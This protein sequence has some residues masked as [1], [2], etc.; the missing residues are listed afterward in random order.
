MDPCTVKLEPVAA[1][2]FL[3]NVADT[4]AAPSADMSSGAGDTEESVGA[5]IEGPDEP[6]PAPLHATAATAQQM[7]ATHRASF[8]SI[9]TPIRNGKDQDYCCCILRYFGGSVKA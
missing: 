9:D 3:L 8:V 1:F 2:M 6:P 5:G 4:D 7:R